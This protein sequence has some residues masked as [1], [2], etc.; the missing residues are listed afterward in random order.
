MSETGKNIKTSE[1]KTDHQKK[2][3]SSPTTFNKVIKIKALNG[4]RV[5]N[6]QF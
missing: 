3:N 6:S 5:T 1:N 2:H 4:V